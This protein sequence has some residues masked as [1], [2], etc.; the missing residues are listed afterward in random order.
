MAIDGWGISC[1]ITLMWLSQDL[2]D[3]R[4]TLV[5]VMVWCHQATS[6]Y[7]RPC[8]FR[9][10][11]PY[12]VTRP[13]WVNSL[14][15]GRCGSN[16]GSVISEHTVQIKLIFLRCFLWCWAQLNAA[17]PPWWTLMQAMA[18]CCQATRHYLTQC[19]I[20]SMTSYGV[21]R[22]IELTHWGPVMPYGNRDL[23]QHWLRQ[24]LVAWWH[25]TITWTSVDLS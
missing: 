20:S 4:S 25:Q 22:D 19:W 7:L 23:D 3:D 17:R 24:W 5:Q 6:H 10:V 2:T 8:W 16:F 1:K 15:P 18:W 21:T 14:T 9:S 11:S 12:D 13:Q